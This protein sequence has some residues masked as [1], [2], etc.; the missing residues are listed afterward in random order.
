[1]T[2]LKRSKRGGAPVG[3]LSELD[4]AEASAVR[5]LR[6]WCD[7]PD[8]QAHVWSD[9]ASVLGVSRGREALQSFEA[10]CNLCVRHGRRPLMRHHVDCKCLGADESCFANFIG[11]ACD[12]EQDDAM[13][14]AATIVK[15]SLALQLVG[16]A[17]EFGEVLQY[18]SCHHQPIA[19]QQPVVLH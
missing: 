6:M 13:L 8:S 5:Y 7:G 2:D 12:G 15:P 17:R 16:L 1:M 10:L 3:Y 4:P 19:S 18:I 14:L 9:F 11:Y